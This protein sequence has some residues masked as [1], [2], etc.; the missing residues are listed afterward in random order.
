MLSQVL[1]DSNCDDQ[2]AFAT[3]HEVTFDF[4][5]RRLQIILAYTTVF[6]HTEGDVL[7]AP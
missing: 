5:P 7:C 3:Q 4:D 1:E 6:G 2:G